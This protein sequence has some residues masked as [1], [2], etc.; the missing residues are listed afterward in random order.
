MCSSSSTEYT[1]H[2]AKLIL[3]PLLDQYGCDFICSK[4]TGV[5]DIAPRSTVGPGLSLLS[6]G[7]SGGCSEAS[8]EIVLDKEAMQS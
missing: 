7:C 6:L 4:V 5:I 8:K 3:V 2:F 1:F